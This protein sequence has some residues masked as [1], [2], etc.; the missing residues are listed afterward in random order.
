MEIQIE[1]IG[2]VSSDCQRLL[3]GMK[4]DE[5]IRQPLWPEEMRSKEFAANQ[6]DWA[7]RAFDAF[8]NSEW[9]KTAAGQIIAS[10]YQELVPFEGDESRSAFGEGRDIAIASQP[11]EFW[12]ITE[13]RSAEAV[14][15]DIDRLLKGE[16][17]EALEDIEIVD[18][19]QLSSQADDG[20]EGPFEADEGRTLAG[21]EDEGART[22]G[23]DPGATGQAPAKIEVSVQFDQYA[24][25]DELGRKRFAEVL[26]TRIGELH[27]GGGPDG[28]AVNLHAPWGAGKTTVLH[29]M[30][31]F[32]E[33]E[34]L[35]EGKRWVVIDFNAWQHEHR[36]PPWWPFLKTLKSQLSDRLSEQRRRT[37]AAEVRHEWRA[38]QLRA[39]APPYLAGLLVVSLVLTL[40][41]SGSGDIAK[42]IL[43]GVGGVLAVITAATLY[44][45]KV[46][47]GSTKSAT[48]YHDYASDPL[49]KLS[50]L[51]RDMIE[52]ADAPVCIFVDDLDRCQNEFVVEFLEGLQTSFR[53]RKVAYVIAA[54]KFWIKTSFEDKYPSFCEKTADR[55]Q[56][57]GYQFLEKIFQFNVPLPGMAAWKKRYLEARLGLAGESAPAGVRPAVA[58][59][60]AEPVADDA[61]SEEAEAAEDREVEN[62]RGVIRSSQPEG[63]THETVRTLS[64][65]EAKDNPAYQAALALEYTTSKTARKEAEHF[66][67]RYLELLPDN[68]R[69][70]KRIINAFGM[71][72]ATAILERQ[73]LDYD[74]LTRWTILE[75]CYPAVADELTRDPELAEALLAVDAEGGEDLSGLP[76]PLAAF[77]EKKMALTLLKN[78]EDAVLTSAVIKR[79][80]RGLEEPEAVA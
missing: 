63:L 5:L 50:V 54:D 41:W 52:A 3:G 2:T 29:F 45:R 40:I 64:S 27:E 56:P 14:W 76:D 22:E 35:P 8:V 23:G 48:L 17:V 39:E 21:L 12:A 28:L 67:F 25:K 37:R 58:A 9:I 49:E 57:L 42:S 73:A 62:F 72:V 78:G 4:P 30:K 55:T 43:S 77:C 71:A 18:E 1:L 74:V 53:H 7:Y 65:G 19:G 31:G 15:E 59:E 38:W 60:A 79:L 70:I 75:Q 36:R 32:L 24:R 26:A 34:D 13:D 16:P 80:T 61:V 11:D 20:E 47:F 6:P 68:P 46:F 10:W 51:F 33:A 69:G 66:L 44:S